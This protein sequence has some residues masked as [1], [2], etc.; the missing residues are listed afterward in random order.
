MGVSRYTSTEAMEVELAWWT[1]FKIRRHLLVNRIKT[2]PLHPLY[3]DAVGNYFFNGLSRICRSLL[4]FH[5]G[6][7]I[8]I[9]TVHILALVE[10]VLSPM[11]PRELFP[12]K[13]SI[14]LH[15]VCK[16]KDLVHDIVSKANKYISKGWKHYLRIYTDGSNSDTC[17]CS[18]AF[19]VPEFY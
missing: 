3:H 4:Y 12:Y 14:Y 1:S 16:K 18:S 13:I 8:S 15:G 9:N 7:Q 6:K 17:Q 2:K 19:Y 11:P 10:H 5:T